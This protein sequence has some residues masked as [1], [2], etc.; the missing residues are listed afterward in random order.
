MDNEN[1]PDVPLQEME[2]PLEEIETPEKTK[3]F[4]LLPSFTFTVYSPD[5][6][7]NLIFFV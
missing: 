4:S 3:L 6:A 5:G 7:D 2:R 1:I